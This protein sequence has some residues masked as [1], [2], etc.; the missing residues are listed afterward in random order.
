M[1]IIEKE[2]LGWIDFSGICDRATKSGKARKFFVAEAKIVGGVEFGKTVEQGKQ[3]AR[4]YHRGYG[5][6]IEDGVCQM[7]AAVGN[8]GYIRVTLKCDP[9]KDKRKKVSYGKKNKA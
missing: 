1:P 7:I 6:T 4:D 2:N 9:G 3:I 8:D 5:G